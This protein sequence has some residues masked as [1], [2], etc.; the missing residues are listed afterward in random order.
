VPSGIANIAHLSGMFFG[1]VL[2]VLYKKKKKRRKLKKVVVD[3]RAVRK[4]EEGYLR[5]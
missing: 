3:E 1:L 5:R 2:G 4:W